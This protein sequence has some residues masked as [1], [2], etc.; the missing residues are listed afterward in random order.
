MWLL[1]RIQ[2]VPSILISILDKEGKMSKSIVITS[3]EAESLTDFIQLNL[4]DVI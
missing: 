4:I 1:V 3:N 2:C